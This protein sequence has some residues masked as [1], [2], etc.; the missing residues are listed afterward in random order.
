[1]T[2]SLARVAAG[3]AIPV[4]IV[5]WVP[6]VG[7]FEPPKPNP[8]LAKHLAEQGISEAEWLLFDGIR[9]A[10]PEQ[11]RYAVKAGADPNKA[12]DS[13]GT[14]FTPLITAVTRYSPD[15]AIVMLLIDLGADVNAPYDPGPLKPADNTREAR[16]LALMA[17]SI[18]GRGRTALHWA[19]GHS[20]AE[21]V[22][23][24]IA[25]G[26]RLEAQDSWGHTP[27]F[28]VP[29][30]R[31]VNAEALLAAGAQINAR[32]Q[33]GRTALGN[34]K[35]WL[36]LAHEMPERTKQAYREYIEWLAKNG[37]TE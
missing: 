36:Q 24:L 10:H 19:A 29:P 6:Q 32:D 33:G 13:I 35:L 9:K 30:D 34:K 3:Y 11:I 1:M 7:A 21:V 26:A 17:S 37:A 14:K 31:R 22:R 23:L 28:M 8:S 5:A 2:F 27:L 18:Q 15:P 25:R 20:S 12:R 16:T 4:L